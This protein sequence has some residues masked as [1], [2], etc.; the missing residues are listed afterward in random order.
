MNKRMKRLS[1]VMMTCAAI[2]LVM[3]V[4]HTAPA[5]DPAQRWTLLAWDTQ[6]GRVLGS[7]ADS[8]GP[9][10]FAVQPDGG[11]LVLDQVNRRV[12]DLDAA[13]SVA[14]S[15]ALPHATFD[16][17]EQVEGR[18][19]L[20]LD[21]LVSKV[22]L[23]MDMKGTV[24]TQIAL[25]GRGIERSGLITA[26]LPRPDGVWLEV[27][28]RHSVKVL[29]RSLSPCERQIIPGRPIANAQS[30]RA[31]L[32]GRGGVQVSTGP[33]RERDAAR[34]ATLT[35]EA[36]IHRI[37]WFDADADGYV[38]IVLHEAEFAYTQPF[39]VKNERYRLVTLDSQL[40]EVRRL[41][42]PWVLTQL[43]QR[44]E[45]R[46]GPDGR[47]WQMAFTP[48]GVLVADWGRRTP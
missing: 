10:S 21:R 47:L 14:R 25:Q 18:A 37:V 46:V 3:S 40:K 38:H 23:V 41:D 39:R 22:L 31:A 6:V 35:A 26:M 34:T 33:R 27:D 16:D 15:I 9:K 42:S 19:I 48:D 24:L 13:G 2:G 5:V 17:V 36:P 20:A 28:H 45:F 32:D 43:D 29:D 1:L 7:E 11:V 12:L 8:E 30:L 44:V 4:A